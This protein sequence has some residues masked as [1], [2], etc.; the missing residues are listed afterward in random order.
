ME[1]YRLNPSSWSTHSVI[2]SLVGRDVSVLDVGC[3]RGYLREICD[4]SCRFWGVDADACAV[5]AAAQTYQAVKLVDLETTASRFFDRQFD[6]IVFG[7]VLEHLRDPE[8]TLA[9]TVRANLAPGGKVIVS[10]PNVAN[11]RIRLLLA[12]GRFDYQESGIL[13]RTHLRFFTYKSA[14]ELIERA[15][16]EVVQTH[17]GT[18]A[19][20]KVIRA[21][22][23]LR[24]LLA[25]AAIFLCAA[26]Q[27]ARATNPA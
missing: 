12:I 5:N 21:I 2:A 20:G 7:D 25:N 4:P 10:L 26:P 15:G 8:R 16:L 19:F 9:A 6:V 11:W 24:G 17:A 27:T 22:P 13:D 18:T 23:A 3:N 1:R 14:R